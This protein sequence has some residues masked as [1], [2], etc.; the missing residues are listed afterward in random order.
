[1][2]CKITVGAWSWQ[3]GGWR[4]MSMSHIRAT[5]LRGTAGSEA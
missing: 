2:Q 5:A 4:V 3:T 1:M